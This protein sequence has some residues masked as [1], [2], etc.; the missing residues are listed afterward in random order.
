MDIRHAVLRL[1]GG[2]GRGYWITLHHLLTAFDA[3]RAE[4]GE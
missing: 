4:M 2:A 3:E 1:S